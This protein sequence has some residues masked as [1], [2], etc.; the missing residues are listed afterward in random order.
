[1]VG[2]VAV[3]QGCVCALDQAEA[4]GL[5]PHLGVPWVAGAPFLEPCTLSWGACE[6]GAGWEQP[7]VV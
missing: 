6:Y 4:W 3:N 5:G 1:M 7:V 2:M